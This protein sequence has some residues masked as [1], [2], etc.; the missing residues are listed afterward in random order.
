[1]ERGVRSKGLTQ[2]GRKARFWENGVMGTRWESWTNSRSKAE[3]G[4]KI[5]GLGGLGGG[6]GGE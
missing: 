3:L 5:P 6:G 4:S 2:G 1:M